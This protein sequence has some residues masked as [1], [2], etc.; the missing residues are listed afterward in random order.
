M[1]SK[2]SA[3]DGEEGVRSRAVQLMAAE[4]RCNRKE[5]GQDEAIKDMPPLTYFLYTGPPS[6]VPLP[7]N[8]V[9]L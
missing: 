5:L 3:H 2:V 1:V 6:M 8:A 9:I 7:N 4:W